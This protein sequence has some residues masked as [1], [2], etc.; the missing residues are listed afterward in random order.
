L[1]I[2]RPP[3]QI[4]RRS[5]PAAAAAAAAARGT[6]RRAVRYAGTIRV[7]TPRRHVHGGAVRGEGKSAQIHL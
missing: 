1:T 2:G 4:E 3:A 5:R 6:I 7:R